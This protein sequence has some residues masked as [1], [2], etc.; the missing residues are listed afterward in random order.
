M[1]IRVVL[2]YYTKTKEE[3]I[4]RTIAKRTIQRYMSHIA[5]IC[6]PKL[7]REHVSKNYKCK[8]PFLRVAGRRR[9]VTREKMAA[10]IRCVTRPAIHPDGWL[11]FMTTGRLWGWYRMHASKL[12]QQK[13]KGTETFIHNCRQS[14]VEGYFQGM[15][16]TQDLWPIACLDGTVF[17]QE[18]QKTKKNKQKKTPQE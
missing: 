7:R 16:I 12:S 8:W 3:K 17:H 2:R 6:F 13:S 15:L 4:K 1:F 18:K 11:K 5:L 10:G 9:K 14:L